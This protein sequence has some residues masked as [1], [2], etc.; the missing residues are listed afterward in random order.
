MQSIRIGRPSVPGNIGA[1]QVG[2][3]YDLAVSWR[4]IH[5]RLPTTQAP[6]V[7]LTNAEEGTVQHASGSVTSLMSM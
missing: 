3:E 4:K 7:S 1:L 2:K 5:F 6:V